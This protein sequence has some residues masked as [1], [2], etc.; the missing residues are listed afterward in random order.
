MQGAVGA[1]WHQY[2]WGFGEC[3]LEE[4]T[5]ELSPEGHVGDSQIKK[6]FKPYY[7]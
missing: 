6:Y 3:L 2:Q 1:H 5:L 7:H 4:V